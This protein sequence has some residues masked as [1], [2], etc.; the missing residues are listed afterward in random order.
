MAVPPKIVEAAGAFQ[1]RRPRAWGEV[2]YFGVS[3]A[4]M[5]SPSFIICFFM[6]GFFIHVIDIW[7]DDM[8]SA[9]V[10]SALVA[11]SLSQRDIGEGDGAEGEACG[12]GDENLSLDVMGRTF[13]G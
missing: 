10:A 1:R 4:I 3:G 8:W 2:D 12:C 7:S 9:D 13:L 6:W 11:A 5:C